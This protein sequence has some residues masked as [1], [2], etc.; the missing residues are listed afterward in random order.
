MNIFAHTF[1]KIS[2]NK[3]FF[4]LLIFIAITLLPVFFTGGREPLG[5][6]MIFSFLTLLIL[7]APGLIVAKDKYYYWLTFSILAFLGIIFLSIFFSLDRYETLIS[8][9]SIT[10]AI[11][12]FFKVPVI[13]KETEN[14]ERWFRYLLWG[15]VFFSFYGLFVYMQAHP[16]FR[17][18][19]FFYQQNAF[20]GFM[21]P[22]L[23]YVTGKIFYGRSFRSRILHSIV[24]IFLFTVFF[25]TF[26]RGATLAFGVSWLI[27]IF[28][29]RFSGEIL[30]KVLIL[31]ML[32]IF[33]SAVTV[34]LYNIKLSWFS[35]EIA[36]T[37]IV[38]SDTIQLPT[39]IFDD[40]TVSEN[41][42][43]AR[44]HYLYQAG[45][46]FYQHPLTGVG[47]GAFGNAMN[48]YRED[49]RFYTTDPHN[50]VARSLVE[51]GI[52]GLLSL[53]FFLYVV[54]RIVWILLRS[55]EGDSKKTFLNYVIIG[56]FLS[57][58]FQNMVNV[59]WIFPSTL[60]L[61]WIVAGM[62]VKLYLD[63]L[64][65]EETVV[66]RYDK[67]IH[68]TL[69][70]LFLLLAMGGGL[71]VL[72]KSYYQSALTALE[73]G[74]NE[75]ALVSYKQARNFDP[76]N[77]LYIRDTAIYY[78][79]DGFSKNTF[80]ERTAYS[81]L[82][83]NEIFVGLKV[84]PHDA[85]FFYLAGKS[86]L[87]QEEFDAAEKYLKLSLN[88]DKFGFLETYRELSNFYLREKRY[89]EVI[90]TL[91]P[92]LAIYSEEVFRSI[93][94]INPFKEESRKEVADLWIRY[95]IAR[96]GLNEGNESKE[97]FLRAEAFNYED[98]RAGI[99]LKCLSRLDKS[100]EFFRNCFTSE[101]KLE[102]QKSS[103]D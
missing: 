65:L 99:G 102:K 29:R 82:A 2:N 78:I 53:L 14:I 33:S 24:A 43:T 42:L 85:Q 35:N 23:F 95:G 17:L 74:E 28:L 51:L 100:F 37:S 27:I 92:V 45:R 77:P 91:E 36:D 57:L 68:W 59:D 58:L 93:A 76:W 40:E 25:L 11:I 94:W 96:A 87:L 63:T 30:K 86:F 20:A 46:I 70:I 56:S 4:V 81:S 48:F 69:I 19:S 98:K 47:W 80:V 3:N 22:S 21:L 52:F 62:I 66:I 49:L 1:S 32:V 89:K 84:R 31:L 61:F 9:A 41:G 54:L 12:L 39:E 101:E 15:T 60:I 55:Q 72:G 50:I 26:A 16:L 90:D 67:R 64:R 88:S 7:L 38:T 103:N 83:L 34:F 44:F 18:G 13:F 8:L 97:A 71:L 75:A 10:G 79:A 73:R 5:Q 6:G